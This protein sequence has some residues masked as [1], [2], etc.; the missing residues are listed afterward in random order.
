VGNGLVAVSLFLS[1][2]QEMFLLRGLG[3]GNAEAA[4]A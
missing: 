2:H 1:Q 3:L 4:K